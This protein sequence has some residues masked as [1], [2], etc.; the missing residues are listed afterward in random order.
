[1]RILYAF[2]WVI[3][4]KKAYNIQNTAKAW[5]QEYAYFISEV[6]YTDFSHYDTASPVSSMALWPPTIAVVARRIKL[7]AISALWPQRRHSSTKSLQSTSYTSYW[8]ISV[9][10]RLF[11][12]WTKDRRYFEHS[13][14]RAT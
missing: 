7:H 14:S 13:E 9:A 6:S 12:S 11:N 3:T 5:N 10:L 2:F 4:Q 1:M 8:I